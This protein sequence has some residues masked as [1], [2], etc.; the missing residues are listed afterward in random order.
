MLRLL[1]LLCLTV[2]PLLVTADTLEYEG[3]LYHVYRVQMAQ[4]SRL[5]LR[6]WDQA[7]KPLSNFGALQEELGREGK[8]IAFTTNAGIYAHGPTPCG[9]T[10]CDGK[11]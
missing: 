6:W 8:K 11:E 5:H 1:I 2:A 3:A 9:L 7:G 10:I 4:Q